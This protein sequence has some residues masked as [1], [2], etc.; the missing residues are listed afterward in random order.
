MSG[1]RL[2]CILTDL[3][4]MSCCISSS[5]SC[6]KASSDRALTSLEAAGTVEHVSHACIF[7]KHSEAAATKGRCCR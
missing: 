2:S 1:A 6:S 4:M 5:S 3:L 7:D